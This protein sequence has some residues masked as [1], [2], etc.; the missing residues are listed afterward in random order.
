MFYILAMQRCMLVVFHAI[1]LSGPDVAERAIFKR[2]SSTGGYWRREE[3]TGSSVQLRPPTAAPLAV[4][5]ASN[6]SLWGRMLPAPRRQRCRRVATERASH[7]LFPSRPTPYELGH[8]RPAW[9]WGT[10]FES[11]QLEVLDY[12]RLPG[13]SVTADRV[14]DR[15][16]IFAP[17]RFMAEECVW[18]FQGWFSNERLY[19]NLSSCPWCQWE[20]RSVCFSSSSGKHICCFF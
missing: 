12:A 13:V 1:T 11:D 6:A 8:F 16:V 2:T 5:Q 9:D 10:R 15:G 20:G 14:A 18:T 7:I 17:D 19:L 3:G 4:S